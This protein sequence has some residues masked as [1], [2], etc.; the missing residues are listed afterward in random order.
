MRYVKR[1][2]EREKCTETLLSLLLHTHCF[3]NLP[4]SLLLFS[5][6]PKS[7]SIRTLQHRLT[8]EEIEALTSHNVE[9]TRVVEQLSQSESVSE[10][11]QSLEAE[12]NMLIR[13]VENCAAT[14]RILNE[15]NLQ[16]S[17]ANRSKQRQ[18]L[19]LQHQ[20]W[21]DFA[22][23]VTPQGSQ[24]HIYSTKLV[25]VDLLNSQP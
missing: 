6:P 25:V 4:P 1:R 19:A 17:K 3:N 14:R 5:F 13:Y 8:N 15:Y 2:K 24:G 11:L 16:L 22:M 9:L 10:A 18:R 20:D 7:P 23:K 21:Q 12:R